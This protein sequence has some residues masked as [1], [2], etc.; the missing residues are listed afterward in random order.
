MPFSLTATH[1]PRLLVVAG[2]GPMLL[3]DICGL[4]DFTATVA[5]RSG[6]RRALVDL[7]GA[8]IAYSFTD[9]LQ[10]GAYAASSLR[11][12]ERVASVVPEQYRV[13]TS[14]RAA[15]KMGLRFRTFISMD[16]ALAWMAEP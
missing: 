8:E 15:Q 6:N 7:R 5:G 16:E 2:S 3:A 14:E 4:I 12:L 11:N 1:D 10:I 13:G 9:H